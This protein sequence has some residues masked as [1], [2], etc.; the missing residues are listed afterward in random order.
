MYLKLRRPSVLKVVLVLN[1]VLFCLCLCH[2]H[3]RSKDGAKMITIF[4]LCRKRYITTKAYFVQMYDKQKSCL[5]CRN[6]RF[7]TNAYI[8]GRKNLSFGASITCDK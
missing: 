2:K 3:V 4:G 8:V 5:C 1:Y 6:F 7:D